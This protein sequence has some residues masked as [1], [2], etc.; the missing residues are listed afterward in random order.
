LLA[1]VWLRCG[2]ARKRGS[3]PRPGRDSCSWGPGGARRP[4]PQS[5]ARPRMQLWSRCWRMGLWLLVT[6][7]RGHAGPVPTTRRERAARR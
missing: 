7:N 2:A 1:A 4:C 3:L 6:D 5:A